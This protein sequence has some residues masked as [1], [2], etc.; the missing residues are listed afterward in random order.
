MKFTID[1]NNP[2][3][4]LDRNT[5]G[6]TFCGGANFLSGASKVPMM[7]DRGPRRISDT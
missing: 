4:G 1:E 3:M 7:T 5:I 6:Q 2:D